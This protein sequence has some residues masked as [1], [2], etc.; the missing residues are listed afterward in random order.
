MSDRSPIFS[1]KQKRRQIGYVEKDGAFDLFGRQRCK[2]SAATGNL[3]DSDIGEILGHVS[4]DGTFI[5]I[6]SIADKLF[7]QPDERE[8]DANT[9][10]NITGQPTPHE[11]FATPSLEPVLRPSDPMKSS[12]D[13]L[14]ERAMGLIR[15]VFDN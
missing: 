4:L 1:T 13:E 12:N 11:L 3:Y 15:S 8:A 10:G 5:G 14:V 9:C 6:S 7:G 2:Y